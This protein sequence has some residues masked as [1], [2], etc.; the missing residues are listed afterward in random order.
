MEN[1]HP[2]VKGLCVETIPT[3]PLDENIRHIDSNSHASDV[4]SEIGSSFENSSSPS[5]ITA[6]TDVPLDRSDDTGSSET[7]SPYNQHRR[8][9]GLRSTTVPLADLSED[10]LWPRETC[11]LFPHKDC[12]PLTSPGSTSGGDY[13]SRNLTP[14]VLPCRRYNGHCNIQT[15]KDVNFVFDQ[16]VTSGSDDGR[17]FI[18]DR[19]SMDIVQILRGDS[20][21]VN[22]IEGHPSLPVIAVSGIDNEVYLFSLPQGGPSAVHR[23]NFPLVQSRQ[24]STAGITGEAAISEFVESVYCPDPYLEQLRLSGGSLLTQNI[25]YDQLT[26]RIL[27]TFPAV[28]TSCVDDMSNIVS[29]NEH[30]LFDGLS[31]LPLTHHLM[32]NIMFRGL[33]ELDDSSGDSSQESNNSDEDTDESRSSLLE[34]YQRRSRWL[35]RSYISTDNESLSSSDSNSSL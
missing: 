33:F 16:Y 11:E 17:V 25:D 23:Q 13:S 24:L 27:R 12:T 31:Q 2:E 8:S 6:S 5:F 10:D 26:Q 1:S 32:S 22:N 18:W 28:S 35:R 14:I 20:E 34:S 30:I 21:I 29:E 3:F 9:S 19:D 4:S 15:V 7:P